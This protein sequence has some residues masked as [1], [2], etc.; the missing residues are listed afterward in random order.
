M[1]IKLKRLS[2]LRRLNALT[3]PWEA[4]RDITKGRGDSLELFDT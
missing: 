2:R 3:V 4:G 1:Q